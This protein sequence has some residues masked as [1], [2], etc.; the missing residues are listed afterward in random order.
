MGAVL[1]SFRT[2][3]ISGFATP[4]TF[5]P[6][7]AGHG[8]TAAEPRRARIS[9]VVY[10][11]QRGSGETIKVG[12]FGGVHGDEMAGTLACYELMEWAARRPSGLDDYELHFYPMCNPTGCRARTR[13]S[14]AGCDLNREFWRNS[15][16]PE[17]VFLEREL[18]RECYD[19]IIS[20]H[21]DD[22]SDGVYGF[23][24]GALLSEHL[25]EPALAAAATILPRNEAPVIDGFPARRGII[26]EGY[27]GI[28]SAPPE[29]R[30]RALELVFETP[31]LA[32]MPNQ[33][34]ATVLA[35]KA[36]L[37]EFK[38]LLA[39]APNL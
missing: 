24:S 2:E 19:A 32:A 3:A 31:A 21:A 6:A 16:Q 29:Q 8:R 33:V 25:L 14:R 38:N 12:F 9:K 18:R 23:V 4:G 34:R 20:L 15:T 36:M 37:A 26:S 1:P 7:R 11:P 10:P 30:P 28:L 27:P 17:V 22:T 39:Y 13:E 35:M 5:L